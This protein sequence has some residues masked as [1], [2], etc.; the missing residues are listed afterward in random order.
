MYLIVRAHPHFLNTFGNAHAA[1][2]A[3]ERLLVVVGVRQHARVEHRAVRGYN[4]PVVRVV[5]PA[6]VGMAVPKW[7]S[8]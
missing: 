4:L 8:I 5:L 2:A 1:E 7:K 6:G 3:R